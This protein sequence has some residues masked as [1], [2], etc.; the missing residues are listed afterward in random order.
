MFTSPRFWCN[1][2]L[3]FTYGR[4]VETK[5]LALL[6]MTR[7]VNVLFYFYY[8]FSFSVVKKSKGIVGKI[9]LQST[10]THFYI[11]KKTFV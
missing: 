3:I 1:S 5:F 2:D 9:R 11:F 4:K 6:T 10:K 8:I 7:A